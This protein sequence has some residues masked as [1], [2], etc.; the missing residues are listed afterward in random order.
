MPKPS[1]Y[2]PKLA[3]EICQLIANGES[4]RSIVKRDGMPCRATVQTWC[5][6]HPEFAAKYEVAQSLRADQLFDECLEIAD[7]SSHDTVT[8]IGKDGEPYDA[9][10][11]EHINRSRLRV[12]T[13]KWVCGRMSPKK[14]G[15]RAVL[16]HGG[17]DGKPIEVMAYT[18]EQRAKALAVFLAKKGGQAHE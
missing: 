1:S 4:L 9:P 8:K 14:Y 13:R 15:D 17:L 16:E 2:T 7:D 18:D 6:E 10:N 5:L 12:D 3:L 11:T